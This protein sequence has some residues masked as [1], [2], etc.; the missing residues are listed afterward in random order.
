MTTRAQ[1]VSTFLQF[2]QFLFSPMINFKF[3][4]PIF[5]VL[6]KVWRK[7]SIGTRDS[8]V[9]Q[10][11]RS[12]NKNGVERKPTWVGFSIPSKQKNG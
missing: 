2:L 10:I 8:P 12:V 1:N 4:C 3:F 11:E 5:A 7:L 9:S 6:D